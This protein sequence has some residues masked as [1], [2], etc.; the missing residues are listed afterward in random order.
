VGHHPGREAIGVGLR[1]RSLQILERL[2]AWFPGLGRDRLHEFVVGAVNLVY[3]VRSA[4][5]AV[6]RD[7]AV[8]SQLDRPIPKISEPAC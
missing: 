5:D 3:H 8:R 7:A 1:L 4:Q 6:E 2:F